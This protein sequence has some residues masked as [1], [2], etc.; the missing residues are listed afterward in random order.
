M[1]ETVQNNTTNAVWIPTIIAQKVLG[2]FPAYLGIARNVSRDSE[3]T[4]AKVGQT[5]QVTK[6]GAVEAK[7]K[8]QGELYE[9]QAP[10]GTAVD[11]VLNKHKHVTLTLDDVTKVLEQEGEQDRYARD[12][13]IALAD[14]IEGDLA[15]L[16]PDIENTVSFDATSSSTKD[17]S[18][19]AVRKY[20]TDQRV[21]KVEQKYMQI[22]SSMM[23][24][25]L[26]ESKYTEMQTRGD[27]SAI[28]TGSLI[29]TYGFEIEENQL[30]EAS[31]SPVTYHNM[32]FT[33]D[34]IVLATRPLP[35]PQ[36]FGGQ[37]TIVNDEQTQMSL[38]GLFWYNADL[39]AHQL[40]LDVLYGYKIVDQR[41][42]VE[43]ESV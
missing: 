17:S 11:V 2:Q 33:R 7:D 5:I 35:R 9:K 30:I 39:G 34:A 36:G 26:E 23:N 22:D 21:P 38:R 1:A 18:L 6:T 15:S 10:T 28:S 14:A 27:G 42:I 24:E 4:T 19:L 29:R 12:A 37:Y 16:H 13:V 20:F 8:A 32:A 3:W 43:V 41:R 40:T 25:L 31:G